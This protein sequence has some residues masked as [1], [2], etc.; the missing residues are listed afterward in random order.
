[1]TRFDHTPAKA[2][3]AR[4][5]RRD[6]TPPEQKLWRCLRNTQMSGHSFRRQHP[7]GW[8]VVDFYCPSAKLAVELD[9]D[10]HA[11]PEARA[12]D[13]RRTQFLRTKGISVL[14]FANH[15]LKENFDGVLEAIARALL[16]TSA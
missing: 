2:T 6:A 4:Q 5:L 1:M 10:Q 3:R 14:R 9:G 16:E 7:I 11:T 13:A 15:D 8:Y 12:Y